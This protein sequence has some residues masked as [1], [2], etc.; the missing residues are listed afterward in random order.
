MASGDLQDFINR[1]IR[2]LPLG[3]FP[4]QTTFL[5]AVIS[6][7]A[8]V[9]QFINAQSLQVK[10]QMRLQT[11]TGGNLDLI[12]QDF[13]G[14][15]L[16]R[17]FQ[18][19]D[20][21]YRNRILALLLQ[22]KA[23]RRGLFNI[24]KIFTGRD[25]VLFE[26]WYPPD[27]GGYNVATAIGYSVAGKYGSNDYPYQ[28]FVDVFPPYDRGAAFYKGYNSPA[29]GYNVIDPRAYG[30]YF[31]ESLQ[32]RILSDQEIYNLINATKAFGTVIWARI[33]RDFDPNAQQ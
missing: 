7:Y 9:Y 3:W 18:E 26:P 19:G 21:T 2:E 28:G 4:V 6:A 15:Q 31:G 24:L 14:N 17:R 30:Y 1:L 23:T 33:N 27:T 8:T 13:F 16:P 22:E 29:W 11:A 12:A 5:S 10:L 32:E 20:E 25:P